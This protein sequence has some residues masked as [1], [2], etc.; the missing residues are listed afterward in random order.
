MEERTLSG[1][2]STCWKKPFCQNL[3]VKC[4]FQGRWDVHEE[5]P[6]VL[7]YTLSFLFVYGGEGESEVR[8]LED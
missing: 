8:S 1:L 3:A 7:S 6:L 5:E 4:S 2:P